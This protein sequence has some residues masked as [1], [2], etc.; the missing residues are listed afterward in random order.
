[1]VE[2]LAVAVSQAFMSFHVFIFSC[3]VVLGCSQDPGPAIGLSQGSVPE[4]GCQA[5]VPVLGC[6]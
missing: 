4:S 5:S 1:M 2:S 3:V 6:L